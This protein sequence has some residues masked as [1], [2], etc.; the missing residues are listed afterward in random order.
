MNR[1][2]ALLFALLMAVGSLAAAP[3]QVSCTTPA[4]ADEPPCNPHLAQSPWASHHRNSWALAS[5]P[6]PGVTGP[7]DQV[8]VGH[9]SFT[10][11]PIVLTF[12]D[13][14][15]DGGRVVWASTVG[16]TGE[17]FKMD[18]E[19][20]AFI[21][22]HIPQL[23]E[24]AGPGDVSI[25]GA[26][27]LLDRDNHLIVGQVD[28]LEVYGD[29]VPGER[30]SSIAVLQRFVLPAAA[31]C[32]EDRL[33]GITL[34]YDGHVAFATENGVVGVVPRQP[35]LM[36]EDNMVVL[37]LNEDCAA[38]GLETVSNT[39]ASDEDG[40]IY[41]VTSH[42]Q[43]R[44]DWDGTA[45]GIGWRAEYA[46]AGFAGGGRLGAGSGSTPSLM[47]LSGEDQFVVLTDGQELMHLVLMW[48]DEIPDDWE[49][50]GDGRDRRIACEIPVTFGDPTVSESLSEQSVLVRGHTAFVVNNLMPLDPVLSQLPPRASPLSQLVS[51]V[52]GNTP[53]GLERFDWDPVTRTCM[54]TWAN[55]DVAIPNGIPSLSTA[56]GLVYGIG[57]RNDVWTL[58]GI[59]IET[60][61]V[62]LTVPSA[63]FPMENSFYAATTVGP[64][65]SVWT[66]TFGGVT[67]W[68]Q[69]RADE[70]CNPLGA[71][72]ALVGRPLAGDVSRNLLGLPNDQ[73][74]A[75]P[76]GD[77]GGDPSID[78]RQEGDGLPATGG[79]AV[80]GI[81]AVLAM[82]LLRR[83][84]GLTLT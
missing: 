11:V 45:L 80:L 47:G 27:N 50:L 21:D 40:G 23:E 42:A 8:D 5:S 71:F 77:P 49:G 60:G 17:V 15:P 4:E 53:T 62:V 13:P 35:G 7:A 57:A 41:V 69:C 54:S 44:I 26:Y 39:I 37:G 76:P 72:E 63:P 6:F 82:A 66:G 74:S 59:D 20:M 78:D 38:D 48:R 67:R 75:D 68:R 61:E 25:S 1:R 73:A 3:P 83:K 70:P 16:A 2:A 84:W 19:T 79:G 43:Y 30:S 32:G 9:A 12:S 81:T 14:Y 10:S 18:A 55:P 64:D 22:H 46:G 29:A 65:E 56:T 31:Q 51:G 34:T 24:G 33:V 58:E 36:T 52:P 28:R